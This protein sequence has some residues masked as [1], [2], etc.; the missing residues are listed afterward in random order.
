MPSY[1]AISGEEVPIEPQFRLAFVYGLCGHAL[2]R[3]QDDVQDQRANLFKST[4]ESMLTGLKTPPMAG[5]TP[6]PGSPQK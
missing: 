5:G 6:G 2:L 1:G 3:D 4:M